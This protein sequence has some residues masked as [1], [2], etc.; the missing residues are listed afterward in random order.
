[1]KSGPWR[2]EMWPSKIRRV[3]YDFIIICTNFKVDTEF[4]GE[5]WCFKMVQ[6]VS[7][8]HNLYLNISY[9]TH[10]N[11][12]AWA[13][14]CIIWEW[15]THTHSLEL[16]NSFFYYCLRKF[17]IVRKFTFF[18]LEM[19]IKGSTQM[20]INILIYMF[21]WCTISVRHI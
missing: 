19:V 14:R 16:H 21:W 5:Q 3:T 2:R 1:M 8:K 13:V 11:L 18:L 9:K 15:T 4:C 12:K 7:T 17:D 6:A 10:M 20:Q